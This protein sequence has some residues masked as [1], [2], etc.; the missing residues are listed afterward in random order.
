MST[1]FKDGA[2]NLDLCSI[3]STCYISFRFANFIA[4]FQFKCCAWFIF[5]CL[6]VCTK[7]QYSR[8]GD[9]DTRLEAK[10]KATKKFRGQGQPFRGQMLSRPR[11]GM[12]EAKAKDRGHNAEAISK[13]K[14]LCSKNS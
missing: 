5:L 12:L 10:T 2:S 14:N 4:F 6:D 3:A 1:R 8:G 9:K 11:T 7:M 13:K